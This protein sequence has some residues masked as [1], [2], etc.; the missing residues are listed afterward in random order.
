ML[1]RGKSYSDWKAISTGLM[2]KFE[3]S[4]IVLKIRLT[5]LGLAK[6]DF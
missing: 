1:P 3:I 2:E 6:F 4:E 5:E